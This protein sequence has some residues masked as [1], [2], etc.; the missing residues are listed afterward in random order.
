MK[1]SEII[2][3]GACIIAGLII[4][5]IFLSVVLDKAPVRPCIDDVIMDGYKI[6]GWKENI[7]GE[8]N[9]N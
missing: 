3:N 9:G 2:W 4:L 5:A 8:Q 7:K 6:I 1:T